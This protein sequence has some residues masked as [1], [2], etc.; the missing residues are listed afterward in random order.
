[1]SATRRSLA[2]RIEK[3]L[4]ERRHS[5]GGYAPVTESD[6]KQLDAILYQL[7]ELKF[8]RDP[9]GDLPINYK[10]INRNIFQPDHYWLVRYEHKAK[11]PEEQDAILEDLLGNLKTA[12]EAVDRFLRIRK[13]DRRQPRNLGDCPQCGPGGDVRCTICGQPR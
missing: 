12:T 13:H 5:D 3:F 2:N 4:R 1:M 10:L 7:I 8:A 9:D 11:T 6:F